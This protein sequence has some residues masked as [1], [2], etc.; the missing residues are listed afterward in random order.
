MFKFLLFSGLLTLIGCGEYV[1]PGAFNESRKFEPLT[2]SDETKTTLTTLC[3]LLAQKAIILDSNIGKSFTFDVEEKTCDAD[4]TVPGTVLSE[5]AKISHEGSDYFF[6]QGTSYFKF[7]YV[8]TNGSGAMKDICANLSSLTSPLK[9][10]SGAAI[11]ISLNSLTYCGPGIGTCVLIETGTRKG[12]SE[13]YDIVS[14]DW[15]RFNITANDPVLGFWI[16][17][18]LQ[19]KSFCTEDKYTEVQATLR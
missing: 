9:A 16:Y 10:A 11:W 2:V 5:T 15:M 3:D 17:R 18:R 7:Q 4:K 19:A 8:E 12:T 6:K 1:I 14:K 13:S